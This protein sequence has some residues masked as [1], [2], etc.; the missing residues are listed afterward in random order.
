MIEFLER[1]GKAPYIA[2]DTETTNADLRDG[3]GHALGLSIAFREGQEIFSEYFPFKHDNGTNRD[4]LDAFIDFFVMYPG[5]VIFHNAKF[6]LVSLETLGIRWDGPF[7]D[8]MLMAHMVD[9]NYPS[10][11]LDWL[12]RNLLDDPGKN[13]SESMQKFIDFMGW[14]AV[15]PELIAEYAAYDANLTLRLYEHFIMAFA[16]QGFLGEY[17][18][19]EQRFVRAIADMEFRGVRIDRPLCSVESQHGRAVMNQITNDLGLNPG[20]PNDLEKL[21]IDE[22][23]LPVVKRTPGGK[24]SFDKSAMEQYEVMLERTKDDRATRI[25]EYR[26]YQKTVSSN[27]DSYEKH[28]SPDGR[29]RCNYKIHGTK[30]GRLSCSD[31]N[32]QQIP[33][34]SDKVWNGRLKSAFIP[35]DGFV[36]LDADYSQI[37]FRLAAA[38]SQEHNLIET[39]NSGEDI[40]TVMAAILHMKRQDVKTLV[41]ATLYGGGNQ[42]IADIFGVSIEEAAAIRRHFFATYPGL[43]RTADKAAN[44]ARTQG[45]VANWAGRRRHFRDPQAE[46][47]KAFNSVIQGGA[48]EIVKRQLIK[49]NSYFMMDPNCQLLLTVHDSLVFEVKEEVADDYALIIKNL[50]EDVEPDFGVKF[51]VQVKEWG[52]D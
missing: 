31:P 34:V 22:L 26:G 9:E 45:W 14:S 8:T 7:M 40:F 47:H 48:A 29:L 32:L 44:T 12:T 52:K 39:F 3:R 30:T 36:L 18:D 11:G 38:Y 20:S 4:D 46:A 5:T 17:W 43:K 25:L 37:E 24:V 2:V 13:R 33:R 16:E 21:L 49:C 6:D 42:R 35:R 1:A 41:Y 50:M 19:M 28:V 51:M 27:Y 10:K 15:T 23:G